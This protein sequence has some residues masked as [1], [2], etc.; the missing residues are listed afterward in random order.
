MNQMQMFFFFLNKGMSAIPSTSI[1]LA[2]YYTILTS[3]D[4]GGGKAFENSVRMEENDVLQIG[5]NDIYHSKIQY[6]IFFFI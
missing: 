6:M 2:L 4:P 1:K 3:N 5:H